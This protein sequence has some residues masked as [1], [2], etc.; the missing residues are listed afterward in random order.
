MFPCFPQSC[1]YQTSIRIQRKWFHPSSK[2]NLFLDEVCC[3]FILWTPW[4]QG[5]LPRFCIAS[6]HYTV[7][8]WRRPFTT[9]NDELD[10]AGCNHPMCLR[11]LSISINGVSR[12]SL[13]LEFVIYPTD[14]Y[15]HRLNVTTSAIK[16]PKYSTTSPNFSSIF[17]H[18]R[19]SSQAFGHPAQ[20]KAI[21]LR[22]FKSNWRRDIHLAPMWSIGFKIRS[23]LCLWENQHV[24]L[25]FNCIVLYEC[26]CLSWFYFCAGANC[27]TCIMFL[28]RFGQTNNIQ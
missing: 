10:L 6:I 27:G 5:D 21:T 4:G 17:W 3:K 7:D 2:T 18:S 28:H 12:Q 24:C 16:C 19:R 25:M 9:W 11:I 26:A 13:A 23:L 8:R 14:A 22:D 15:F 20:C 1:I